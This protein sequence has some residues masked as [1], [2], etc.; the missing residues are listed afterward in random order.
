MLASSKNWAFAINKLPG[1]IFFVGPGGSVTTFA[2]FFCHSQYIPVVYSY[3]IIYSVYIY[4][5]IYSPSGCVRHEIPG[6]AQVDEKGYGGNTA[7]VTA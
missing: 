1:I 2:M 4:I 6:V 5:Y 7:V 3:H